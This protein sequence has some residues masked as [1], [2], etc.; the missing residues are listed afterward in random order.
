M[1]ISEIL[2]WT[3]LVTLVLM[4]ALFIEF[5]R[6]NRSIQRLD[7]C[8][9]MDAGNLPSVSIVIAARNE[10][11]HIE[12][13]LRSV[14]NQDLPD[15]EFIIV[16]DRST[17][18]TGAILDRMS[19]EHPHLRVVHLV[20]L[21]AGWLGKTH[22]QHVG[23]QQATGEWLLFTDADVVMAPSTVRR[24]LS[25][26]IREGRD[27]VA[28]GPRFHMP[29][30]WLNMFAGAFVLFFGMYAKPW[31]ARDPNS[32]RFIGIG[33]FNLVRTSHYRK[34]GGHAPIAMRPDDDMKLGKLWKMNGA[35]QEFLFGG[36]LM[37]VE[38]YA[39]VRELVRG[40][41]K[42]S[43][44]G[45]DY[46]LLMVIGASVAQLAVFVWP[47]VATLI[48]RGPVQW[49][50]AGNVLV[51]LA[52]YVDNVRPHRLPR[53]HCMGIP[54]TTLLFL[55]IV[56]NSTIKALV[57]DGIDWRGTHYPLKELKASRL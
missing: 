50:N 15:T 36:E 14:L 55:Y 38:W 49:L 54:A 16:N 6:G 52:L 10:A 19:R 28:V 9:P 37:R 25:Y 24:A 17:D 22:A 53:W 11:R 23:A 40:L 51:S 8:E 42:N 2:F 35:R 45:V 44:A 4:V 21:P 46:S 3:A 48:M 33:A 27:H 5:A 12:E 18:D 39:T 57:N 43:F 26:A 30:V 29:G 13:A 7:D 31:K 34:C 32:K 1:L 41:E 20:T 56:W 47:W